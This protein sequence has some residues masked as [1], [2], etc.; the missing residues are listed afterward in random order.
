MEERLLY[1]IPDALRLLSLSRAEVYKLISQGRLRPVKV[2]RAARIPA[3]ELLR[4]VR[5]LVAEQTERA[6]R[7]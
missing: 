5:E 7:R 4:F 2:G 6:G 3:E 1:R